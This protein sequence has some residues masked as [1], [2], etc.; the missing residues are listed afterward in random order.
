MSKVNTYACDICGVQRKETNHWLTFS[1]FTD[2]QQK[3]G[4]QVQQWD[5]K[6]ADFSWVTHLCGAQCLGKKVAQFVSEEMMPKVE[7]VSNGKSDQ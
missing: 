4:F 2:D 3:Q 7:S 1:V 6:R 5:D